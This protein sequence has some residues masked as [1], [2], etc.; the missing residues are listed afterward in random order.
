MPRALLFLHSAG[1]VAALAILPAHAAP[2]ASAEAAAFR[3]AA[4]AAC[5]GIINQ[6][7]AVAFVAGKEASVGLLLRVMENR[8]APTAAEAAGIVA[9]IEVVIDDVTAARDRLAAIVPPPG[10][11]AEAWAVL[12]GF[13]DDV[14]RPFVVRR[15][16]IA[17]GQWDPEVIRSSMQGGVGD[18]EA[19]AEALDFARRDCVGVFQA[20]GVL[21]AHAGFMIAAANACHAIAERRLAG[22]Y[23]ADGDIVLDAVVRAAR[24]EPVAVPGLAAALAS[25]LAEWQA[26]LTDF[27]AV[28]TADVTDAAAWTDLLAATEARIT[29]YRLRIAALETGTPDALAAAFA[30]GAGMSG[31]GGADLRALGLEDRDCRAVQF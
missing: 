21:P 30:P 28:P 4:A 7:D 26:T 25:G 11:D 27:A 16:M 20:D 18:V 1:I 15:D 3:S 9:A 5:T 23:S 2:A 12:V 6:R 29:A 24:G 22:D 31:P 17:A 19:A 13:A 10:P 8:G 14:L